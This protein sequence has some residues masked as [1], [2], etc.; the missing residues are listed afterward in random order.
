MRL[1][2]SARSIVAALR[3]S[4]A[5]GRAY[6]LQR[7]GNLKGSLAQAHMGLSIL[8]KP[9]VRRNNPPEGSALASLTFLAEDIASQVEGQG[10]S[11]N[12]LTD[13]LGFLKQL[14]GNPLPELCAFIPFLE[15][16]LAAS[17]K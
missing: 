12:D 6:R 14:T 13:S 8:S 17:T 4:A 9:Y 1:V 2:D 11:P 7:H 16:R 10:A 3:A 5:L 15:A